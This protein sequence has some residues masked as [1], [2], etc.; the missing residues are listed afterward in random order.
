MS[1][2]IIEPTTV[3][4][5]KFVAKVME[6]W[7]GPLIVSRGEAHD[8]RLLEGYVARDGEVPVGLVTLACRDGQCQVV[9]LDA[10]RPRGGIGTALL[11]AAES[12][13]AERRCRRLWLVTTNDNTDALRFYQRRG[14]RLCALH[15]GAV[16]ECRKLKPGIPTTGCWGIEL[17]DEV[18]LEK[19][20]G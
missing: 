9:T 16:A 17:R 19:G 1:Q 7:G 10:L 3:D 4:D 18:E 2:W 13:A 11:S 5:G 8:V 6:R 15:P 20:L 14:F 12:Y